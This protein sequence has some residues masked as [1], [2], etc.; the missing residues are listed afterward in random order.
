MTAGSLPEWIV[1]APGGA[2]ISLRVTPKGG[3]NRI[4]EPVNGRLRVRVTAAPEDG[5]ANAAVTKL[6]AKALRVSRSSIE[7]ASGGA[8]RD[9]VVV[10]TGISAGEAADAL[11]P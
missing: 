8:S 5:K 1:D 9:K 2:R 10:V 3:A 4:G 6:L 7:V 11:A